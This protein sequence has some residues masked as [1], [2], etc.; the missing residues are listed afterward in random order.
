MFKI[1]VT[2]FGRYT[3][4]KLTGKVNPRQYVDFTTYREG[5]IEVSKR[6]ERHLS[7]DMKALQ[8][9]L[10]KEFGEAVTKIQAIELVAVE[11]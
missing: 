2:V 9:Y 6:G 1:V 5:V 10:R 11:G 4:G 3:H 7:V 8:G